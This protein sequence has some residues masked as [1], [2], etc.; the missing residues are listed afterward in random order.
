MYDITSDDYSISDCKTLA[1][2]NACPSLQP[3]TFYQAEG[4]TP[5]EPAVTAGTS[6]CGWNR[7][8]S[9]RM[10]NSTSHCDFFRGQGMHYMVLQPTIS[11]TVST[12]GTDEEPC[13]VPHRNDGWHYVFSTSAQVTRCKGICASSHQ[14]SQWTRGLQQLDTQEEMWSPWGCP[15]SAICLVTTTQARPRTQMQAR[16]QERFRMLQWRRFL[17]KLEQGIRTYWP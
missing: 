16:F 6:R 5:V 9:Q 17:R 2:E 7:T 3:R 12:T 13:R 10:A 14:G 8:M 11:K 1:T 4:V 15:N